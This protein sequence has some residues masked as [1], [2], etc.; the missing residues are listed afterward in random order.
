MQHTKGNINCR[1]TDK[2]TENRMPASYPVK[3]G[4]TTTEVPWFFY[5]LEDLGFSQQKPMETSC[6]KEKK[7]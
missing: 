1:R 3:A 5:S 2:W 6:I 7:V 4:A